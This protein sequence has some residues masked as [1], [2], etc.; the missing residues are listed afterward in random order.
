MKSRSN[1]IDESLYTQAESSK[2]CKCPP[3]LQPSQGAWLAPLLFTH[4]GPGSWVEVN[5]T[6]AAIDFPDAL[7]L[8]PKTLVSGI[9]GERCAFVN[10][11][12]KSKF[13]KEKKLKEPQAYFMP[14]LLLINGGIETCAGNHNKE[15]VTKAEILPWKNPQHCPEASTGDLDSAHVTLMTPLHWYHP[16]EVTESTQGF[17]QLVFRL[18]FTAA[19]QVYR[20]F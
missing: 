20:D 1:D 16:F 13:T 9:S 10:L 5:F 15:N 18:S 3:W 17:S 8:N 19:A 11:T 7:P 12:V 14:A 6:V 4:S 2:H